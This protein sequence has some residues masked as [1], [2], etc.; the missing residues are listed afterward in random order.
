MG[1]VFLRVSIAAALFTVL[2]ACSTSYGE[3]NAYGGVQAL[4]V[5][6]D[7]YRVSGRGNGFTDA[8]TVQDYVLLKAAETTIA[9][10]QTHFTILDGR[11]ATRNSTQQTTGSLQAWGNGLVTYTPGTTYSFVYPGEDLMIRAWTPTSKQTLPPNT[12]VAK[13]TFDAINPRVT[14]SKTGGAGWH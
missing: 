13:E 4:P 3:L 14:R 5:S 6:A 9:K 8:P 10:G 2:S 11:D 1:I 7:V 12:F